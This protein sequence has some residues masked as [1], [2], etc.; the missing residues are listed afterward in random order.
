MTYNEQ[1]AARLNGLRKSVFAPAATALFLGVSGASVV[2]PTAVIAQSYSFSSVQ[3]VGTERISASTVLSY[4]GIGK[5]QTV[6]AAELNDAYQRLTGS[7][8]FNTVELQPRGSTLVVR[9]QE[10][11][12][13]SRINVEGNR[14]KEDDELIA[15][16]QS[17]PRDVFSPSVAERD[18]QIIAEAYAADG[19]ISAEVVPRIIRRGGGRVDLVFEVVEGKNAEI[20]RLSFSGNRAFT[21]SRLRRVLTSKQAGILRAFVRADTFDPARLEFDK[22]VLTDFYN[23]RGFVDFEATA[24]S[25]EVPQSRDG[26]QVTFQITEGQQFSLG[27][28]DTISEIDGLDP[29]EFERVARLNPGTIY[30]PTKVDQAIARMER[31]AAQKGLTFVNVEPRVTRNDREGT[32]DVTLAIVRGP[33]VIVERIDIEG[34]QTTLDRVVRSQF[35]T[36]EGDPFNPR[37]IRDAAERIRALGYFANVDVQAR[38]GSASDRV[39]VDVDVEEQGTGSLSFGAAYSTATGF[40]LNASFQETNFL[41]RGQFIKAAFN[42]GVTA[43]NY[44]FSF[45]EPNLFGRDLVLGIDAFYTETTASAYAMFDSTNA[46][47]EPYLEFPVSATSRVAVRP[48]VEGGRISNVDPASSAVL[49]AEAARGWQFGA[50]AGLTYTFDTARNAIDPTSRAFLRLTGDVGGLGADNQYIKATA[51][52]RVQTKVLNDEVTLRAEAEAGA[53]YSLNGAGSRITDRFL[54]PAS[55]LRGFAPY[56]VGPRDLTAGNMDALGGNYFAVA[57]AE[58]QFPLGLPEEYGISG[59]VFADVGTLWGLDNNLGGTIDDSMYLRATVGASLFWDTPV[60]P[61]RFNYAIPLR[62]QPYDNENRFE[63]T[64]ST[65]F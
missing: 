20:E 1:R 64:I 15:L 43:R 65:S 16:I 50:G 60:G 34:N 25:A 32:L 28:V 14:R 38:E 57:R 22:Q 59:G 3:I 27:K 58:A 55:Q 10:Y 31:L 13:I 11:S 35:R 37:A 7:G 54:L 46:R 30:N 61:L 44:E 29:A 33:R 42:G 19:R 9:V 17:R 12:M 62:K 52:A 53:V 2:T 39:V 56:G 8:L 49:S 41:G 5:G 63:V 23:S 18:A 6:S 48:F 45:A 21:D 51:L 40:G 47:I 4:L 24:V 36:V 26:Y